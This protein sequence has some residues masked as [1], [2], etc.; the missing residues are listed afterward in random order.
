[1]SYNSK[2]GKVK[3]KDDLLNFILNKS[4]LIYFILDEDINIIE[5]NGNFLKLIKYNKEEIINYNLEKISTQS[6]KKFREAF[7]VKHSFINQFQLLTKDN[8][9][10]KV[11]FDNWLISSSGDNKKML[12]CLLDMECYEKD[13]ENKLKIER[14]M[15]QVLLDNIPD[16]IYFKDKNSRFT[17][18][19]KAQA[20]LLG[21]NDPNEAV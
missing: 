8:R 17:R 19:N 21:I 10:L 16:T 1:M 4:Q 20:K 12:F 18:I 6:I 3:Y 11:D 7:Q 5:F 15:F 9:L 13:T 2:H 14:E